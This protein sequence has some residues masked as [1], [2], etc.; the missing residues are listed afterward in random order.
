MIKKLRVN[1]KEHI[2]IDWFEDGYVH[3]EGEHPTAWRAFTEKYELEQN[4]IE[5]TGDHWANKGHSLQTQGK[6]CAIY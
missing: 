4:F 6:A 2:I 1:P 5:T 3:A